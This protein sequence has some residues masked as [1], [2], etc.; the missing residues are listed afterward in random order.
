MP[1]KNNR[2]SARFL[3]LASLPAATAAVALI[4][5]IYAGSTQAQSPAPEASGNRRFAPYQP[6]P[7]FAPARAN[8]INQTTPASSTASPTSSPTR[9]KRADLNP[10]AEVQDTSSADSAD[11]NTPLDPSAAFPT[12]TLPS[13]TLTPNTLTPNTLTPHTLPPDTSPTSDNPQPFIVSPDGT[14]ALNIVP[15]PDRPPIPSPPNVPPLTPM[16]NGIARPSQAWRV[17][18]HQL[19]KQK[20]D[21]TTFA[22]DLNAAYPVAIEELRRMVEVQG[23]TVS[24]FSPSSGHILITLNDSSSNRT[25]KTILAMRT[26]ASDSTTELRVLCESRNRSLTPARM[27]DILSRLQNKFGA[28]KTEADS[29]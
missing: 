11:L 21:A 15:T 3:K 6:A 28:M 13:S 4:N 9:L 5:I 26:G 22:L 19:F 14:P 25:E 17:K 18:A 16:G 10:N 12:K 20:L 24:G 23:L 7:K 27:K 2:K 1:S 29:L 8:Q